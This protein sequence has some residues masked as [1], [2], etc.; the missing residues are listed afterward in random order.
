M[1]LL[2][3]LSRNL[4]AF[5][6]GLPGITPSVATDRVRGAFQ[7]VAK[8]AAVLLPERFRGG[9][10]FGDRASPILSRFASDT[11]ANGCRRSQCQSLIA[12]QRQT[13]TSGFASPRRVVL[14]LALGQLEADEQLEA[15]PR[16]GFPN[17]RICHRIDRSV[18][19]ARLALA[20]NAFL[21]VGR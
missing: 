9:C 10:S 13:A 15:G 8:T 3:P 1:V 6:R 17:L 16:N 14:K 7:S 12:F 21:N 20:G 18:R 2:P 11:T 5:P 19:I 4:R